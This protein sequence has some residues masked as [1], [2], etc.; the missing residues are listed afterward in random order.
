MSQII[1]HV[2]VLL[3]QSLIKKL[4]NCIRVPFI[5]A[6]RLHNV[7]LFVQHLDVWVRTPRIPHFQ[8]GKSVWIISLHESYS[9][10][11]QQTQCNNVPDRRR[12]NSDF[13]KVCV[14]V[15]QGSSGTALDF[16]LLLVCK[17]LMYCELT[18]L[19]TIRGMNNMQLT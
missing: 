5:N 17:L 11:T 13:C 19:P 4:D 10:N 1:L 16:K 12:N 6:Q 8:A 7:S 9:S 15:L 3:L 18:Q 14:G 2:C